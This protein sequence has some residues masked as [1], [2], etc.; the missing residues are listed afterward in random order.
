[1]EGMSLAVGAT[2]Q[3][4]VAV[5]DD[6]TRPP[7]PLGDIRTTLLLTTDA[8]SASGLFAVSNSLA[9]SFTATEVSALTPPAFLTTDPSTAVT[10]D[11]GSFQ[12][13]HLS[14][15][16]RVAL[17]NPTINAIQL[18]SDF[19]TGV[20]P[21]SWALMDNTCGF[22][23]GIRAGFV[24]ESVALAPHATCTMDLAL[25]ATI[26]GDFLP[27]L[28]MRVAAVDRDGNPASEIDVI[29]FHA[30]AV[31]TAVAVV[32]RVEAPLVPGS[33]T[34]NV[35][36]ITFWQ[37]GV[38]LP[39]LDATTPL[40]N[41][42]LVST[43]CDGL[44]ADSCTLDVRLNPFVVDPGVTSIAR[45]DVDVSGFDVVHLA[46]TVPQGVI[47]SAPDT[48][49]FLAADAS[50]DATMSV[51]VNVT[52]GGQYT[53][54]P[55]SFNAP[56]LPGPQG[57]LFAVHN[58]GS[59]FDPL[60][61]A[62][63]SAHSCTIIVHVFPNGGTNGLPSPQLPTATLPVTAVDIADSNHTISTEVTLTRVR[64]ANDNVADAT[65]IA[66]GVTAIDG[67]NAG[68]TA[69]AF[70]IP[71][72]F[73]PLNTVW[74]SWTAPANITGP[75]SFSTDNNQQL[76]RVYDPAENPTLATNPP[77]FVVE[78]DWANGDTSSDRILPIAGRQY[79]ISV[80]GGGTGGPFGVTVRFDR[81]PVNDS[82]SAATP[83]LHNVTFGYYYDTWNATSDAAASTLT[84]PV[85]Y[86]VSAP[87]VDTVVRLGLR[88]LDQATGTDPVVPGNPVTLAVYADLSGVGSGPFALQSPLT[89]TPVVP[90]LLDGV[91]HGAYLLNA[92]TTYAIAVDGSNVFG[93]LSLSW[94]SAVATGPAPIFSNVPNP[95]ASATAPATPVT[96][97]EPTV[98][99]GG[100]P[101]CA[102]AS[103]SLFP[104]GTTTVQCTA[105][106]NG[107]TSS[108]SFSVTVNPIA[109]SAPNVVSVTPSSTNSGA[110]DVTL[111]LPWDGGS[112]VTSWS[113]SSSTGRTT[114]TVSP[115]GTLFF[116]QVTSLPL[117]DPNV[118]VTA[119]ATNAVGTSTPATPFPVPLLVPPGAT[120]TQSQQGTNPTATSTLTTPAGTVTSTVSGTGSGTVT[121]AQYPTGTPIPAAPRPFAQNA[122]NP[123]DVV[124]SRSNTF[125]TVTITSCPGTTGSKLW[126]FD[127]DVISGGWKTVSPDA[128]FTGPSGTPPNCLTFTANTTT[129]SPTI[130]GLTGTVFAA[131]APPASATLVP[132][133]TTVAAGS[134]TTITATIFDAA[135]AVVPGA[136]V[137]LS[138]AAGGPAVSGT[139]DDAGVVTLTVSNATVGNV[140]YHVSANGI[141]LA[142]TTIIAYSTVP[143]VS[144]T[145]NPAEVGVAYTA[146]FS[147]T[148][149]PTP[150]LSAT[151]L[152]A[153]LS[154]NAATG[155]VSGTPTAS[156]TFRVTVSATNN[157]G[158]ASIT[159]SLLVRPAVQITT[160]ALPRATVGTTYA[161][162]IAATGGTGVF[163]FSATGLP[164][165]LSI[166]ATSGQITGTPTVSGA[167]TVAML[168]VDVL[169]GLARASLALVVDPA[170]PPPTGA[171]LAIT[172]T[173]SGIRTGETGQ[174]LLKVSNTGTATAVGPIK[175]IDML[176][177][178]LTYASA[179][180]AGWRCTAVG[181]VVT[182]TTTASLGAQKIS[183]LT[184]NAG[185]KAKAG[186]VVTNTATVSSTATDP[187]PTNNTAI[188]TVTVKK[189]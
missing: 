27:T 13:R 169:G 117:G 19:D 65:V 93:S 17:T 60:Q 179:M 98:D 25:I 174:Y 173:A 137:T 114:T 157:L 68:A 112:P 30:L 125:S 170:T 70:E 82:P 186:T 12:V 91:D 120:G 158:S 101:S 41:L 136:S 31:S 130:A 55:Y 52:G 104:V 23:N 129:T 86:T 172:A 57:N 164:T 14:P 123:F 56:S 139:T 54:T 185:V 155:M 62:L 181:Q 36:T 47:Y 42:T 133:S 161:A 88:E 21:A 11:L 4:N 183:S 72:N 64:P 160:T 189:G 40:T 66:P 74:Y 20:F 121:S 119:A 153:G 90:G 76:V 24:T 38:A 46:W 122:T 171:D 45:G 84:N 165:G 138:P 182:C 59:C 184:L 102:P 180:G 178:G 124:V 159:V 144:G 58:E 3:L 163:T 81:P 35:R 79:L 111:Q 187:T 147:A 118:T 44:A 105:T 156:G 108:A 1:L 152:P 69:E 134:S 43:T 132:A 32:D 113:V 67:N 37:G 6:G 106:N 115:N 103:G 48:V 92:G 7:G 10:T 49:G 85:W 150:T 61:P 127:P 26:A 128:T 109:P 142:A 99:V 149:Q 143:T 151:G 53:V 168:V 97:T 80:F 22:S 175:V 145:M 140:T 34:G 9:F 176:P 73:G 77:R 96:Y 154:I 87:T 95:V 167:V 110:I 5:H 107:A 83:T 71:G 177:T 131:A 39:M 78:A 15:M 100:P 28:T 50:L 75:V 8:F 148:G 63:D 89:P 29:P 33:T 135:H 166:N 2:C 16:A 51:T 94:P 141:A 116:A 146:T 162:S 18:A 188:V 126:W